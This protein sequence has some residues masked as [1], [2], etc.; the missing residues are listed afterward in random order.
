MGTKR[1][2][3]CLRVINMAMALFQTYNRPNVHLVTSPIERFHESGIVTK[4]GNS[5]E[6]DVVI[7]ATGFSIMNSAIKAYKAYGRD[8][9]EALQ[10]GWEK[11]EQ[12]KAYLGIA[13]V[14]FNQHSHFHDENEGKYSSDFLAKSPKHVLHAWS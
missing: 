13:S 14:S 11:N 9:E 5:F 3:L 7:L 6:F 1:E 4:D 8:T 12:P 10:E 2:I